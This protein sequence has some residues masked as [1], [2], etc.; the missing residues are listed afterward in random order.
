[1]KGVSFKYIQ[2]ALFLK[3]GSYRERF[4]LSARI[5]FLIIILRLPEII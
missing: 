1:M 5:F 4:I 3:A 2:Y